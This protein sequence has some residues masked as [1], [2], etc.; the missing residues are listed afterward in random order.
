MKYFVTVNGLEIASNLSKTQ[1]INL[2]NKKY[3]ETKSTLDIGI[4][5][6]RYR[7]GKKIYTCIPIHFYND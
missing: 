4:G 6:L 2:G 7:N 5:R 3:K 1:A